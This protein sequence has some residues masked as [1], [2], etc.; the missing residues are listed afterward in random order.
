MGF[1]A[2]PPEITSALIHSGP[3]AASLLEASGA[4]Q[5]VAVE[6]EDS[7]GLYSAAVTSLY[8]GWYGPSSAAMIS[9]VEPYIGW[10]RAAAAQ[11]VQ[12]SSGLASAASSFGAAAAAVVTPAVVAANRAQLAKLL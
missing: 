5:R 8:A 9:A 12:M 7:A 10:M 2:A 6:L 4:W 1:I 3:G 11:C